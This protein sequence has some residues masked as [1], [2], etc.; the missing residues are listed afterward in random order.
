MRH[1]SHRLRYLNF[2]SPV[3]GAVWGGF[4]LALLVDLGMP[5]RVKSPAYFQVTLPLVNP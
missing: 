4:G 5:S 1:V 2:Q 3:G